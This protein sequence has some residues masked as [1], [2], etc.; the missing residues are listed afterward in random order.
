MGE[1]VRGGLRAAARRGRDRCCGG[2]G[3]EVHAGVASTAAHFDVGVVGG[4]RR[5]RGER[6]PAE[7]PMTPFARVLL[8]AVAFA[9]LASACTTES[10]PTPDPSNGAEP[11]ID[12][13]TSP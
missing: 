2:S 12:V 4:H 1:P 3:R 9:M 6:G 13:P 11:S 10:N 7:A 5:R 8:V